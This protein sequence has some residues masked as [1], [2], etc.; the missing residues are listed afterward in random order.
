MTPVELSHHAGTRGDVVVHRWRHPDPTHLVLLAHGYGEHLGRYGHVADA[1]RA[2]G[3]EVV[4]PDHL[5][6]GRSAGERVLVESYDD[7]L[8]DFHAVAE[9]A[10]TDL[11][12]VLVGHSMGGMIAARYAQL[13]GTDLTAVVLSGPVLGSWYPVEFADG[14]IPDEPLDVSTLSRDPAVGERYDADPLIWH[15]PFK[16]STLRAVGRC[17]DEINAGPRLAPP[18]LWAHGGDDRL[19]PI[20]P[21]R[22]GIAR[23][24]N[25]NLTAVEYPGARHEIF[26]ETNAA[27]VLADVTRFVTS[28]LRGTPGGLPR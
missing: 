27:A 17:L 8:A 19:V 6:H 25:D 15:G 18:T 2:N 9:A 22:A 7:V 20:G 26:N 28:A 11:P 4:G 1:F 21:T 16:R 23:I 14:D 3:A 5:G 10:R 13:H 24:R 12:V